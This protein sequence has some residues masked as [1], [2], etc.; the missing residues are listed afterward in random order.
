MTEKYYCP[1]LNKEIEEGKCIEINYELIKAK[2]EEYLI[3][4]RKMLKRSNDEIKKTCETC[5]NYPL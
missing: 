2:K 4:I 5:V 3:E 1:L